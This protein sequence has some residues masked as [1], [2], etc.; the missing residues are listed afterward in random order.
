ML[1]FRKICSR[2]HCPRKSRLLSALS[3]RYG[4]LLA[5]LKQGSNSGRLQVCEDAQV[6]LSP[7]WPAFSPAR[8]CSKYAKHFATTRSLKCS[9][10]SHV[11]LA[12][13]RTDGH[14]PALQNC[15]FPQAGLARCGRHGEMQKL[16]SISPLV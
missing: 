13:S 14:S 11:L 4:S 12:R 10:T 3:R 2:Y 6:W 15:R 7:H 1:S 5:R 16:E 8:F 9:E